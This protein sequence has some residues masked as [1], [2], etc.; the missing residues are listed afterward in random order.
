MSDAH[1][2][3]SAGHPKSDDELLA[4]AIPIDALEIDEDEPVPVDA[5]DSGGGIELV[6]AEETARSNR[7]IQRF[8]DGT[9]HEE[10]WSRTPNSPGTGAIHVKTFISKLRLDAIEHMDQQINEWLDA[11]PQYEVKFVTSSTGTLVGKI[12]EPAL[13]LNVWV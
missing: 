3:K 4:E 2:P 5:G 12:N 11:H 10:K 6:A 13:F 8:G 1:T 9:R 7:R